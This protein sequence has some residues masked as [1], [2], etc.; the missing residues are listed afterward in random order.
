M[1]RSRAS[2]RPRFAAAARLKQVVTFAETGGAVG[3]P[4]AGQKRKRDDTEVDARRIERKAFV[5]RARGACRW[6]LAGAPVRPSDACRAPHFTPCTTRRHAPLSRATPQNGDTSLVLAA[7]TGRLPAPKPRREDR[8]ADPNA[9]RNA[10]RVDFRDMFKDVT[11]LGASSFRRR[12]K[13]IWEAKQLAAAGALV[14]HT[15][16]M[17]L[18]MALG[19]IAVSVGAVCLLE[20]PLQGQP[21]CASGGE[22]GGRCRAP[23]RLH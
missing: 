22:R 5:V 11:D 18:K 20:L 8:P 2:R 21:R 3:A 10:V 4:G 1:R 9:D 17:P 7:A 16:K 14:T 12:D 23:Q 13:K 19:V 15:E 6:Q